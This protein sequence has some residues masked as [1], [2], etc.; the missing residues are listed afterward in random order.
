MNLY[1]WIILSILI[2]FFLLDTL[3]QFLNFRRLTPEL[4]KEF[5]GVYD[6]ERYR[7]L[8]NYT[9]VTNRL[10]L[11]EAA[12]GLVV[13]L[14][15]WFVGGFAWLNIWLESLQWG[16][17]TTGLL[18]FALLI[19]AKKVLFIGFDLYDT[20]GVE[21]RFGFNRTTPS[22]YAADQAKGLLLTAAL[23]GP[24]A[25]LV[26][27]LFEHGGT[28]AWF[29]G[30]AIVSMIFLLL[31]YIGP[32]LILPLFHKFTPLEE[33]D[34]REEI[35]A[36]SRNNEFPLR[37][38]YVVD[39]SRRSSR[40]NAFF[41]GFGRNKRVALFDTLI[42]NHSRDELVAVLAHEVGHFRLKHIPMQLVI[43]FLTLGIFFW[44]ASFF[45]RSDGLAQAFYL[46]EA[47]VYFGLVF[48]MILFEPV[49]RLVG[50]LTGWISRR[51]EF[52]ADRFAAR[53]SGRG[54]ALAEAL[55]KLSRDNLAHLTPHPLNV[56]L[57]HSHPPVLER[58]RAIRSLEKAEAS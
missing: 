10:G 54:E 25:A 9:R 15:F 50:L 44:L 27:A 41:T 57:Y 55:L 2:G 52:A 5:Q 19:V 36:Y 8:V 34:L 3:A 37:E 4:P 20:F 53:T 17:V 49:S 42:E 24:V 48:F 18:C 1:T 45:V 46:P 29:Y 14:V 23:G 31:T 43:T 11:I 21:Q 6:Q 22:T 40:A 30:W 16:P 32:R 39:G 33:G 38:V 47:N 28:W 51:N 26:L 12:F 56:I 58:V 13:L 7:K 35:L